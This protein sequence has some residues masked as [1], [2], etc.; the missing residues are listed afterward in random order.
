VIQAAVDALTAGGTVLLQQAT[1]T[2]ATKISVATSSLSIIGEGM[3]TKLYSTINDTILEFV[4]TAPNYLYDCWVRN[5]RITGDKTAG[6]SQFGVKLKQCRRSGVL[7]CFIEK[8][9]HDAIYLYYADYCVVA[10]NVVQDC[11][12][13]GI[14]LN[15]GTHNTIGNNVVLDMANDGIHIYLGSHLNS[16][17]GNVVK[18]SGNYGIVVADNI[19]PSNQN[20][21]I[22]NNVYDSTDYGIYLNAADLNTI[23]GNRIDTAP[24]GIQLANGA[25]G[26][27]ISSNILKSLTNYGI[28]LVTTCDE[29]VIN[30]NLI[31]TVTNYDGIHLEDD[32][33]NNIIEGNRIRACNGGTAYAIEILTANAQD[34]VVKNNIISGNNAGMNDIG[35]RT[36]VDRMPRSSALDLCGAA[37]DVEI[38][39][40]TQACYLV[41]YTI[42]YTELSSVDAGV[43]IRIGR[44]QDGVALDDDYFDVV[45]SEV[46][47]ALGYAKSYVTSDL[48][49]TAIAAGDT[50]TVGT[51]GGK[52]GTGTVMIIPKIVS[53]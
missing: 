17:T 51:A 35:T 22:G 7:N 27:V 49:Q 28:Y 42:F 1:Y 45:T 39:H 29:N 18:S 6:A 47:K 46:S 25:Y 34:N 4:E 13:D 2:I 31:E 10:N 44:Y 37:T 26:N 12:D 50:V 3:G 32:N 36:I 9:G 53:G 23:T 11:A 15:Y 41:G 30:N 33:D 20:T 14:N 52:A 38:F 19:T 5:L 43:N 21:I 8:I 16:I 24:R 48:T 40:A